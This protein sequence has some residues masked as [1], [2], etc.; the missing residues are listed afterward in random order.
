MQ[1]RFLCEWP[2]RTL[3][4]GLLLMFCI[5]IIIILMTI[6]TII[7]IIL[8][9]NIILQYAFYFYCVSSNRSSLG[10]HR[11]LLKNLTNLITDL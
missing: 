5:F 11:A 9:C 6:I 1:R 8:I 7:V 4:M 2:L 3:I 10:K